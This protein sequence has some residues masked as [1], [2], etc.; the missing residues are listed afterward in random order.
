MMISRTINSGLSLAVS[1]AIFSGCNLGTPTQHRVF[2]FQYKVT[3][4]PIDKVGSVI[5]LWVPLP[6]RD[7]Y[8]TIT[9]LRIDGTAEITI[10]VEPKY[11]NTIAHLATVS[12]QPSGLDLNISFDVTRIEQGIRPVALD[13]DEINLNLA[14][15]SKVPRDSRFDDIAKSIIIPTKPTMENGR[16]L[17]D[18]VRTHMD[19]DKSGEGWGQGDAIYACDFGTGNCSDY[20]SLFNAVARTVN[21]P[22]RFLIGFTVN[23]EKKGSIQG[24]HCWTEFYAP[25]KGW[26]PVDISEADKHPEFEDYLFGHLDPNRV[27]F[28]IGRDI[29]L[30][31]TAQG[32]SVNFFIY[33]ILE[34]DGVRS[35]NYTAYFSFR[36]AN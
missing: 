4:P 16:L 2:H 11:G 26:I 32:E 9:N 3:I 17:Y 14:P 6:R 21:I 7:P 25:D 35:N 33:P 15:V 8:Q 10:H 12:P 22:T 5:K 19:Y 23:D 13:R 24:Y 34:I 27:L 20:H 28:T 29:E 36:P 31:P 1:V 18:F 30:V